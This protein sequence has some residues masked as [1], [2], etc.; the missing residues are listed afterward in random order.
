MRTIPPGQPEEYIT[1]HLKPSSGETEPS[2][3]HNPTQTHN[4]REIMTG[5]AS[6]PMAEAPFPFVTRMRIKKTKRTHTSR[7]IGNR[8]QG[9][10][11]SHTVIQAALAGRAFAALAP[12]TRT[13][14]VP[15]ARDGPR[16]WWK[17]KTR[18]K[19]YVQ[20][21]DKHPRRAQGIRLISHRSWADKTPKRLLK[22]GV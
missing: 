5:T 9:P 10:V 11:A 22:Q 13:D 4:H 15:G 16:Q 8:D 7:Q 18:S 2:S 1:R 14:T 12:I 3:R 20:E 17:E 6:R 21:E 19:R